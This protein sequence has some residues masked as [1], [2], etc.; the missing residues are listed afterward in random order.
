MSQREMLNT[1]GLKADGTV[2]AI[3]YNF[4]GE[5]DVKSWTDIVAVSVGSA[6]IVGLK[7][8]GTVV[9]TGNNRD[10]QCNVSDWKL[11]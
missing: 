11:W 9:A 10:R 7:S 5:R 1:V 3:G 6:H 4:L 2:V 8:D